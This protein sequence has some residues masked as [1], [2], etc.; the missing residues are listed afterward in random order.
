MKIIE[1]I[2]NGSDKKN[3]ETENKKEEKDEENTKIIESN[4]KELFS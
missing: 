4:Q 1:E 3:K 2:Q